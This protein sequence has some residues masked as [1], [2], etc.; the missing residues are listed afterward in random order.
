MGENLN[1]LPNTSETL[2]AKI[3]KLEDENVAH[4]IVGVQQVIAMVSMQAR[5]RRLQDRTAVRGTYQRSISA[6]S[7]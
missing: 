1:P 3:I 2:L 4:T 6:Q 7:V 5:V